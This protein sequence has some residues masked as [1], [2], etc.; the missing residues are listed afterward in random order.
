M[1]STQAE[2]SDE[3]TRMI[4]TNLPVDT[5]DDD[6]WNEMRQKCVQR[7]GMESGTADK[8]KDLD[9][10]GDD[11]ESGCTKLPAQGIAKDTRR[12]RCFR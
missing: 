9:E 1:G 3:L 5:P 4:K 10:T 7:R 12:N 2:P 8:K 11:N 6:T